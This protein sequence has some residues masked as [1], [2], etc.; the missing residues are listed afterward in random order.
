M[1]SRSRFVQSVCG[2]SYVYTPPALRRQG[3]AS[4]C[5]ANVS[6]LV[7]DQGFTSCALYTDL[8]NPISNSIYQQIGYRPVC[9]SVELSL[10]AD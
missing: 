9:D 5:V 3:Y 4:S 2:I 7:L 10:D 1:A 8:A 6:Q